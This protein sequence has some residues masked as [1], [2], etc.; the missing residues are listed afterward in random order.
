M[1]P[2][3]RVHQD[4]PVQGGGRRGQAKRERRTRIFQAAREV[5]AE[6]D[7]AAATMQQIADRAGVAV[8]T[9]FLHASSK[10]GLLASAFWPEVGQVSEA[11]EPG[12]PYDAPIIDQMMYVFGVLVAY[13]KATGPELSAVLL[14]E[15]MYGQVIDQAPEDRPSRGPGEQ[16][17][18]IMER[19][20]N[21]GQL[22]ED[23]DLKQASE[24]LFSIFHWQLTHWSLGRLGV[25]GLDG[26]L[27]YRLELCLSGLAR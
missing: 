23:I 20:R 5:F 8:G 7:F 14:R 17:R 2:K 13:H 3:T 27:R 9:L 21:E 22:R 15:L 18:T 6:R 12:I 16:I 10:E 24:M 25:D 1:A 19:A 4:L 11:A 26:D